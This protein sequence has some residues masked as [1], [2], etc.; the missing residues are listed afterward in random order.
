[1][2]KIPKD[3]NNKKRYKN[4]TAGTLVPGYWFQAT[5]RHHLWAVWKLPEGI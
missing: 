4:L 1:M 5:T 2:S 3:I